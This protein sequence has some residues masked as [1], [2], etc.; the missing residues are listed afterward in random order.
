MT[1]STVSQRLEAA[2]QPNMKPRRILKGHQVSS[3][4]RQWEKLNKFLSLKLSETIKSW[5]KSI[6]TRHKPNLGSLFCN[7]RHSTTDGSHTSSVVNIRMLFVNLFGETTSR[8]KSWECIVQT[9]GFPITEDLAL[10]FIKDW[11]DCRFGYR[12]QN[13]AM[14]VA[15]NRVTVDRRETPFFFGFPQQSMMWQFMVHGTLIFG[16]RSLCGAG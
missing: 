1:V 2:G 4:H 7:H 10:F 12:K 8:R 6:L 14:L 5:L 11:L 16:F 15:V 9:R 3:L 13:D